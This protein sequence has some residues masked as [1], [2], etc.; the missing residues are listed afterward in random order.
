MQDHGIDFRFDEPL[1]ERTV[2]QRAGSATAP[3][4]NGCEWSVATRR[5]PS[6]VT[7]AS[8]RSW[9]ASGPWRSS[10]NATDDSVGGVVVGAR[11]PISRLSIEREQRRDEHA[12]HGEQGEPVP[13]LEHAGQPPFGAGA[14]RRSRTVTSA[15][16][17]TSVAHAVSSTMRRRRRATTTPPATA[18]TSA[19]SGAIEE[20][21]QRRPGDR[22]P[23]RARRSDRTPIVGDELG[24]RPVSSTHLGRGAGGGRAP[25]TR[26]AATTP[27]NETAIAT[28]SWTLLGPVDDDLD[29]AV[30]WFDPPA[31]EAAVDELRLAER[32]VRGPVAFHAVL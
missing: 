13:R 31:V 29:A 7:R 10:S 16:T 1:Q 28:S 5:W 20:R 3:R 26:S 6:R 25:A 22:D 24:M 12:H 14:L 15:P 9:V 19:H 17:A 30:G 11:R 21:R 4:N 18:P 2:R 27:I 23:R 32:A 8:W